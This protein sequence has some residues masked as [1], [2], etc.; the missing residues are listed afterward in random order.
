MKSTYNK[1]GHKNAPLVLGRSLRSRPCQRRYMYPLIFLLLAAASAAHAEP[2]KEEVNY[3]CG[4]DEKY[5]NGAA[6]VWQGFS[7]LENS[8]SIVEGEAIVI[9]HSLNEYCLSDEYDNIDKTEGIDET[10]LNE[11]IRDTG[12]RDQCSLIKVV[13]HSLSTPLEFLTNF[14]TRIYATR[15]IGVVTVWFEYKNNGAVVFDKN[16]ERCVEKAI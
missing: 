9:E 12:F 7:D 1:A 5:L 6:N 16:G 3:L 4:I 8:H 14:E 15:I 13:D 11:I 2:I 10:K